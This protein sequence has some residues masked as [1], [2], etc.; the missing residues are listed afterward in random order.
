MRITPT[1]RTKRYWEAKGYIVENVEKRVP[2]NP[3]IT[4]DFGGFAD[5]IAY[6]DEETIAIQATTHANVRARIK[7]A[8][9]IEA[10]MKWS[11]GSHRR[12]IIQGWAL[13]GPRGEPKKWVTKIVDFLSREETEDEEA[14]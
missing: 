12:F 8:G 1:Q 14:N 4:Q 2:N 6:D 7:K 3:H 10:A 11:M 5:L 9:G 13:R